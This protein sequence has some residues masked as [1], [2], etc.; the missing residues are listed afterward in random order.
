MTSIAEEFHYSPSYLSRTYKE[1]SGE[2][3]TIAISNY[4]LK[5]AKQLL[6]NSALPTH[7]IAQSCGFYSIKYFMQVFKAKWGCTPLQYRKNSGT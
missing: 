3:L 7:E 4:R 1:I 5:R 2:S 6:E